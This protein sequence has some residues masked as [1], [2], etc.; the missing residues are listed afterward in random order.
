MFAIDEALALRFELRREHLPLPLKTDHR[1]R[2]RHA[3]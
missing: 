3:Q 1:S 2:S